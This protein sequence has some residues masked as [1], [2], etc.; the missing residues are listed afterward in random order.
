M[1]ILMKTTCHLQYK[2]KVLFYVVI[3]FRFEISQKIQDGLLIDTASVQRVH[4]HGDTFESNPG[5]VDQGLNIWA[6][7]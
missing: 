3:I 1:Q 4:I 5:E 7:N 2:A 6:G